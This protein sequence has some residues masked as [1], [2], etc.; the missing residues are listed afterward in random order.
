[1]IQLT[2]ILEDFV[3][4]KLTNTMVEKKKLEDITFPLLFKICPMIGFNE[5]ALRKYGYN[6]AT[7]YFKGE[8]MFNGAMV[9]WG[10]HKNDSVEPQSSVEEVYAKVQNYK[11]GDIIHSVKVYFEDG[12]SKKF[13]SDSAAFYLERVNY[14]YNCFTLNLGNDKDVQENGITDIRF[15]LKKPENADTEETELQNQ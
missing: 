5:T 11:K 2:S 1:M 6:S 9:G 7:D 10:G 14:P 13:N 8:S 4:P 3:N 15:L 12:K